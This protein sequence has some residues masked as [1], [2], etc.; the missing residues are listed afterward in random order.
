M[1]AFLK[2]T[3]GNMALIAALAI[4]PVL[5]AVGV[6]IDFAKLNEVEVRLQSA[7][8]GAVLAGASAS[9]N[10]TAEARNYFEANAAPEDLELLEADFKKTGDIRIDGTVVAE[11]PTSFAR[12]VGL[13]KLTLNLS[14]AAGSAPDPD[15][16]SL[17]SGAKPQRVAI[18]ARQQWRRCDWRGV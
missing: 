17:H 11:L 3:S 1:N 2:S 9:K 10:Y 14:A 12:L 5:G 7:L 4:A 18:P 15:P 6:A 13:D 16:P 8:D